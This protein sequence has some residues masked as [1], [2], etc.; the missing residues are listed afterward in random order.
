MRKGHQLGL[1]GWEEIRR[2]DEKEDRIE[3]GKRS[4]MTTRISPAHVNEYLL[5]CGSE[6]IRESET[7]CQLLK[8]SGV[9]L[10]PLLRLGGVSSDSSLHVLIEDSRARERVQIE[11]KYEGYL[12][13]QEEQVSQFE[14]SESVEIPAG[15]EFQGLKSLSNEGKEKLQRVRP[16]SIG[17]AARI[18]GVTPADISIL[19][20][21]LLR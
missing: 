20:V 3:R 2:L 11:L 8:R 15:F 18:S 5:S 14:K 16:R 6:P 7:L 10:D 13:R 19:L 21:S 9:E 4:L 17:Q 12:R 1:I